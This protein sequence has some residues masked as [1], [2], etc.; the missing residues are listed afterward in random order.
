MKYLILIIPLMAGCV[1][2]SEFYFRSAQP[3]ECNPVF[4]EEGPLV[5]PIGEGEDK[6]E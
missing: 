2:N 6:N 4:V 1:S 5:E 3:Q